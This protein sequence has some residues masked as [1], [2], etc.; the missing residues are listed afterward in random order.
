MLTFIA[1]C[2]PFC[3]GNRQAA[4]STLRFLTMS[5]LKSSFPVVPSIRPLSGFSSLDL[6][7]VQDGTEWGEGERHWGD[8][9][10]VF[11]PFL[12]AGHSA[13]G[14]YHSQNPL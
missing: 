4:Q 7:G 12:Y 8:K 2:F 6:Q 10:F 3:S 14:G 11:S 1:W 9:V 5:E 13:A